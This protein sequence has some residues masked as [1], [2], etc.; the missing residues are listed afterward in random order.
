[1]EYTDRQKELIRA[2]LENYYDVEHRGPRKVTWD[3][4]CGDIFALTDIRM[5]DEVL[6][7]FVRRVKRRGVPRIPDTENLRAIVSLLKHVDMLSDKE[8]QEP[9]V[10]FALIQLFLQYLRHDEHSEILAPP[11][12]LDG[13]FNS[14][15]ALG[16]GST[17][18][19]VELTLRTDPRN[20]FIRVAEKLES[21]TYPPEERHAEASSNIAPI[22]QSRR[23]SEGWG[24]LTPEDNIIIFMKQRPYAH[25]HFYTTIAVNPGLWSQTPVKQL[26]LLRHEYPI[27]SSSIPEAPQ[28][29]L[30]EG[31]S[32]MICLQF[33]M[34][35]DLSKVVDADFEEVPYTE[36]SANTVD[37]DFTEVPSHRTR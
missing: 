21:Y 29:V 28:D 20:H 11:G 2:R 10:P 22:L 35:A 8:L 24:I 19:D 25:N 32:D 36:N 14:A 17:R 27:E 16:D 34:A 1:M 7:Q 26:A 18:I 9:D 15:H 5:D 37:A 31:G 6:R 13:V 30:N 23:L 4:I 33:N 3:R 12:A